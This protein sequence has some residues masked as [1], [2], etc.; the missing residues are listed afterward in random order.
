LNSLGHYIFLLQ[1]LLESLPF[2]H[3]DSKE[4]RK[5]GKMMQ[6][7]LEV[8]LNNAIER[9]QDIRDYCLNHS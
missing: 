6:K 8:M 7:R 9:Q 3:A 2:I 5:H 1:S 4:R